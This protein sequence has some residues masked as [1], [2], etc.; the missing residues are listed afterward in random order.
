MNSGK[1]TA[2][3]TLSVNGIAS[4]TGGTISKSGSGQVYFNG[5]TSKSSSVSGSPTIV[6]PGMA[7]I[8]AYTH[9][10][11]HTVC[12]CRDILSDDELREMFV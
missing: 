12:L 10:R 3:S 9:A 4:W 2:T 5:K 1:I 7:L 8:S 6:N 11:E